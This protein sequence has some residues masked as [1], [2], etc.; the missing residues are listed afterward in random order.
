V[1]SSDSASGHIAEPKFIFASCA[2]RP[3]S[4]VFPPHDLRRNFITAAES[5][6][7]SPLALKALVATRSG[8]TSPPATSDVAGTFGDRRN[9]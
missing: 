2:P 8:R 5:A 9:E 6:D 4:E 7:I 1:F 3:A